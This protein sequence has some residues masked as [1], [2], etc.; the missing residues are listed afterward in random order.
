MRDR[1][2][3]KVTQKKVYR[4]FCTALFFLT[5]TLVKYDDRQS[6]NKKYHCHV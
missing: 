2:K 4:T 3:E 5:L 1:A 6:R